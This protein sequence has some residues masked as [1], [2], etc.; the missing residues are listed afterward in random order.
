[1]APDEK[2]QLTVAPRMRMSSFAVW[3]R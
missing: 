1:V 3:T 2:L